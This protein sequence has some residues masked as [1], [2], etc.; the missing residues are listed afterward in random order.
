MLFLVVFFGCS[1]SIVGRKARHAK[2]ARSGSPAAAAAATHGRRIIQPVRRPYASASACLK[3][4]NLAEL[5]DIKH[6]IRG[7]G[8]GSF[9]AARDSLGLYRL[10]R[11]ILKS[12]QY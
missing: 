12:L 4:H 9:S 10:G 11:C 1:A 2:G 7:G 3:V 5:T 8:G 6:A